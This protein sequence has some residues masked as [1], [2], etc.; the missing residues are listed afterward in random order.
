MARLTLRAPT[1][2]MRFIAQKGSV[3]LDGVSLTVNEVTAR[4]ILGADHPAHAF[5]D[6]A[7]RARSRRQIQPRN[8]PDGALCG[9]A[10]GDAS[11][12]TL[13]RRGLSLLPR[14][15]TARDHGR[16]ETKACRKDAASE[17]KLTG[18][19]ILV[20]EARFYD[21]IADALLA[22]A[23]K[24]LDEAGAP[25]TS[26]PCPARSK[27]AGH[28]HRGRRAEKQKKPYDG[29]VALGCVIQGETFHFDI[30]V[31]AV[32]A[33]ADGPLGRS[34]GCRSATASSP[35]TPS[36]QAWARA[37]LS[38]RRQ[39]RRRRARRARADR[40]Q[41][42]ARQ[43]VTH[44]QGGSTE[45]RTPRQPARRRAARRRAG[46]LPDGSRRHRR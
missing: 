37:R 38:E 34:A 25:A 26:S 20:V 31:D 1:A 14:G 21:D 33:R 17:A 16:T 15:L 5:G 23:A 43:E 40:A 8:R 3:A 19:R 6:H 27:S 9:A 45:R 18:A 10:D 36:A 4:H 28:R 41:T 32:G 22:G 13:V 12:R 7:R 30:V 39:G 2:L 11:R 44:G 35:S 24:V 42:A 46:A 29:V